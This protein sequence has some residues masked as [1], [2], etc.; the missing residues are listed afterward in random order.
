MLHT[1]W[2]LLEPEQPFPPQ[3]GLGLLHLLVKICVPP[4][5]VLLHGPYVHKLHPPPTTYNA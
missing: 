2:R 5:H 3:E 1:S 4:P